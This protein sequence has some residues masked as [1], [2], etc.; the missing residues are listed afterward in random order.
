MM[1]IHDVIRR[2]KI[3]SIYA[4]SFQYLTSLFSIRNRV[5]VKLYDGNTVSITMPAESRLATVVH[6]ANLSI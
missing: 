5:G 3:D 1:Y 4:Q 2:V 6:P